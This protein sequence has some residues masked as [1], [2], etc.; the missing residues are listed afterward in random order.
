MNKITE[1]TT[2]AEIL[3]RPGSEKILSRY[4]LPCL[5][6]PMSRFE[7]GSL[8]LGEVARMYGLDLKGM[9]RELNKGEAKR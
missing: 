3:E 6:C 2:L 7:A 5:H 9:L 4:N 8:K 1:K